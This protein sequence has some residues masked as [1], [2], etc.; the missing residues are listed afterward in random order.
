MR[1]LPG[2]HPPVRGVCYGGNDDH[3]GASPSAE[4]LRICMSCDVKYAESSLSIFNDMEETFLH[5]QAACH[6]VTESDTGTC[7]M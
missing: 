7:T 2:C 6:A 5:D 3:A 1:T 4:L